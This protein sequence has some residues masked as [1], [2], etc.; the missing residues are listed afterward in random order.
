MWITIIQSCSTIGKARWIGP[1]P[2]HDLF[3]AVNHSRDKG[4]PPHE[5]WKYGLEGPAD[6]KLYIGE[7]IGSSTKSAKKPAKHARKMRSKNVND[8]KGHSGSEEETEEDGEEEGA[9]K[10]SALREKS[11]E[12]EEEEE[13]HADNEENEDSEGEEGYTSEEDNSSDGDEGENNRKGPR[14]KTH[15][16]TKPSTYEGDPYIKGHGKEKSSGPP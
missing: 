10:Q 8:D 9:D 13:D 15:E 16:P 6:N 14:S 4:Y 12:Q 7:D 3:W 5:G 11:V 1:K 2:G